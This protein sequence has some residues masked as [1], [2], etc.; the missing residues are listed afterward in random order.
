MCLINHEHVEHGSGDAVMIDQVLQ[1]LI[2]LM[3]IL[4]LLAMG[5]GLTFAEV[6][7]ALKRV[8]IL[9]LGL[10]V[11]F[12]A[13]PALMLVLVE[14]F[15][16]DGPVA[17]GL[18]LCVLAPGNGVGTLLVDYARGDVGL[19][20]GLVLVLTLSSVV[21]TP[22]LLGLWTGG[23]IGTAFG[24]TTW[25][26]MKLIFVFQVVPL[27]AGLLLRHHAESYARK[28]QPW[29]ARIARWLVLGII[30]AILVVK[31]ELLFANG[32]KPLAASLA[33]IAASFLLGWGPLLGTKTTGVSLGLTSMIRNLALALLLAT[34]FFADPRTIAAML[35]YAILMFILAF[36]IA[37]RFRRSTPALAHATPGDVE[38]AK[39]VR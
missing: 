21:L 6:G 18:L 29:I 19:S 28:L 8:R 9:A 25:P 22:I 11:N 32:P 17:V 2:G 15:A 39:E 4:S 37:A 1:V 27:I 12:V 13:I 30:A 5:M 36:P 3:V 20:V 16:I 33:V 38:H 14:V 35:V 7:R 23:D 26:M 34:T 31:G 24:A 10:T